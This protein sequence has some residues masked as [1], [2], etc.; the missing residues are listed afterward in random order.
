M[1]TITTDYGVESKLQTVPSVSAKHVAPEWDK[2]TV[3][4]KEW[5]V[6]RKMLSKEALKVVF[7]EDSDDEEDADDEMPGLMDEQIKVDHFVGPPMMSSFETSIRVPGV[8]H[9]TQNALALAGSKF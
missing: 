2:L 7:E 9:V 1:G 8:E 3:N 4:Q 6:G 5:L